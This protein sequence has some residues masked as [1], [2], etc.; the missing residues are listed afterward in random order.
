M[1]TPGDHMQSFTTAFGELFPRAVRLARRILGDQSSAEDV[2][3]ETMTRALAH[4]DRI[5]G[6]AEHRKAWVIRVSTNLAIDALRRRDPPHQQPDRH[7]DAHETV[8]LR[9]TLADA[10]RSLPPRQREVV[11]LRYLGGLS[12]AEVAGALNISPGTVARHVH[13]ALTG[14]RG[15]LADLNPTGGSVK[16]SSQD[17][18]AALQGSETVVRARVVGTEGKGWLKVDIGIP[19]LLIRRGQ[20]GPG[21]D[22]ESLIGTDVDCVVTRVVADRDLVLV[23][24]PISADE[25]ESDERTRQLVAQL[26]VGD[27]RTGHV[28]SI[29]PFGAFVDVGDIYGLVHISEL[30]GVTDRTKRS[31]WATRCG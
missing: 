11:A 16:V 19:A 15:Q 21:P 12:Q 3:A 24:P 5:G 13:R 29:V 25:R 23:A 2:A 20:H 30:G 4:W 6:S 14:L 28:R 9:L 26:R 27:I 10:L 17:E 31:A 7:D 8:A 1:S 18:A 22:P